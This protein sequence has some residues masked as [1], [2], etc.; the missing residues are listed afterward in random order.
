M[1]VNFSASKVSTVTNFLFVGIRRLC[2]KMSITGINTIIGRFSEKIVSFNE[3]FAR[4]SE[5]IVSF[6]E[7]FAET[8]SCH[9]LIFW[10]IP[11]NESQVAASSSQATVSY[12]TSFL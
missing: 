8:W 5:K 11:V 7:S 10:S 6:N 1:Q 12:P 3:S 9:V 4:F 2:I